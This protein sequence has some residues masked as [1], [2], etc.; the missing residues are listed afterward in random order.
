[1]AI[2]DLHAAILLV[3]PEALLDNKDNHFI[4]SVSYSDI[5]ENNKISLIKENIIER[6][7]KP[8]IQASSIIDLVVKSFS[9]YNLTIHIPQDAR[10]A[11][12]KFS[13]I[14]NL[15]IH[16]NGIVNDTY[17]SVLRKNKITPDFKKGES[18]EITSTSINEFNKLITLTIQA[19]AGE[20]IENAS[21]IDK[22]YS[23]KL[24]NADTIL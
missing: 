3:F 13:S 10:V 22:H 20:I 5:Y 14:R 19:I 2:G 16:N 15:I 17:I 8:L 6:K 12:I 18:I 11:L 21:R 9:Q 4:G 7:I 23:S 1:M 24:I